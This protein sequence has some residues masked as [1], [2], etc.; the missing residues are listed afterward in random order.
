[1]KKLI[2]HKW[3][4]LILLI[5]FIAVNSIAALLHTKLDLTKEKRYTITSTTKNLLKQL[6][7]KME[8]QVFLAGE[9]PA[10]F[11]KLAAT[12][13]DFLQVLKESNSGKINF[14]FIAPET[15]MEDAN[16]KYGDT[17]VS[18]GAQPINLTVQIKQGQ[19][20]KMLFPYALVK[21]KDQEVLVNLYNGGKRVI[22]AAELNNAEAMMEYN[23]AKAMSSLMQI[24]KPLVAYAIGN[25]EAP[26]AG[27]TP[28]GNLMNPATFDLMSVLR[29]DYN[30]FTFDLS[31]R[32][33]IPDTFKVLLL[34]KP[35]LQ[36][37]ED[38][39]LKMDQYLM[40]GGK[41]VCFID[42]LNAEMDSLRM[43][44]RELIA[45]DRNLNL[46]DFFFKY[47]VRINTDLV[48]DL[49]CGFLPQLVG[50]TK[51]NPQIE[52]LPWNYYPWFESKNNHPINKNLG[53]VGGRFVN[54]IDTI[55]AAGISKTI[56]LSTS[57]N[58]RK[59]GT[60]AL[61]SFNEN[62]LTPEDALFKQKDIPVATLLEGKFTSLYRNRISQNQMDTLKQQAYSYLAEGNG[63]GKMIVVADGDMV[64]NDFNQKLGP[65]PMGS[66][67]FT[68]DTKYDYQLANRD[69]LLNSLEYLTS[70]AGL[71]ATRNREIVLR[72]L[73][74][75][76]VEQ[77]KLQWQ[78][79]NIA[80]PIVLVILAG[81]LYMQIRK[82]AYA[83]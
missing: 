14:K 83:A 31:K 70:N 29:R 42:N 55:K 37:T 13:K 20:S 12:T 50:G 28:S 15:D 35:T 63:L 7:D 11:K 48:M 79:I 49:Q 23:F 5:A 64:L 67:L 68:V 74:T 9:L 81:L 71:M 69:F 19:Q 38:E 21:Y 33:F 62:R 32:L 57:A 61:I 25:G 1:M 26:L 3:G 44:K 72:L 76:K 77:E 34:V 75:K 40:R 66:N 6:D 59:L 52:F 27:L 47:G 60:P 24:E 43:G 10:G 4:W 46:T 22:T 73:D 58:S 18:M 80:V 45:Y 17:L 39:K 2:A 56:L 41:I 16:V 53:L 30:V 51:E 36:F 8:V 54:S 65:L 78:I 82:R